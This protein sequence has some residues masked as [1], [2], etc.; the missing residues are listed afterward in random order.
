MLRI[1]KIF[2]FLD[3]KLLYTAYV[4]Y[5]WEQLLIYDT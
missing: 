3:I 5:I 4:E 2:V 1:V